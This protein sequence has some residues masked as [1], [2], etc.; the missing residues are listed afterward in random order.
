[1]RHPSR[2]TPAALLGLRPAPTAATATRANGICR[3]LLQVEI[4]GAL[5]LVAGDLLGP[6]RAAAWGAG[7][8]KAVANMA[9][10]RLDPTSRAALVQA[11]RKDEDF[12]E[13]FDAVMP[14]AVRQAG[15]DEQD[16]W[17][18]L[19]E[20][21]WPDPIRPIHKYHKES[22]HFINLPYI[23][24]ALDQTALQGT[25]QPNVG[26]ALPVPLTLRPRESLN[27]VR[28]LKLRVREL[29]DADATYEKR[30][31]ALYWLLQLGGD[32]PPAAPLDV[33]RRP[34]PVPHGRGDP[35]GNRIKIR[36]GWNL[37]SFRGGLLGGEQVAERHPQA[38]GRDSRPRRSWR[39][40]ARTRRGPWRSGH[41]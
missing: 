5:V 35:G 17:T 15:A 30:A 33:A 36:S 14:D 13:R 38:G 23:L 37:H 3:S 34:P 29:T 6:A 41:G 16:R 8:H 11:L 4:T 39:R 12:P 2:A 24:S 27:P 22:W 1:M 25:I 32:P 10:D 20:A 21:L 28:A 9:Y 18:F 19:Q 40:P 7:G 31:T 26:M